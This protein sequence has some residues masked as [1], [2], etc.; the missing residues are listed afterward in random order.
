MI[1]WVTRV[2]ERTLGFCRGLSATKALAFALG[3]E[4]RSRARRVD[5][6]WLIWLRRLS[7]ESVPVVTVA[8]PA[9]GLPPERRMT[10][11]RTHTR[12]VLQRT[13][14]LPGAPGLPLAVARLLE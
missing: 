12:R 14:L 3:R 2:R 13:G 5:V 11:L 8:V 9:S 10:R 6:G 7:P 4:R 1:R